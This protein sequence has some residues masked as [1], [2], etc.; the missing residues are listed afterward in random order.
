M[1]AWRGTLQGMRHNGAIGRMGE[2]MNA[3]RD[4]VETGLQRTCGRVLGHGASERNAR[5]SER[6]A[7]RESEAIGHTHL[8][9][10][11]PDISSARRQIYRGYAFTGAYPISKTEVMSS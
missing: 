9:N 2:S 8:Y 3:W 11:E 4:R 10:T 7:T 5:V 6:N 1:G